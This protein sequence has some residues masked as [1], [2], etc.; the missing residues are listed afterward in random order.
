MSLITKQLACLLLSAL[1]TVA[2]EKMSTRELLDLA[3]QKPD[4]SQL[5]EALVSSMRE[6]DLKAGTSEARPTFLHSVPTLT[7]SPACPRES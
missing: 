3:L 2:A 1:A 7:L 4:S 6:A 5:Q